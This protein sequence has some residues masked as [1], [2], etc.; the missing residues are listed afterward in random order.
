MAKV[1]LDNTIERNCIGSIIADESKKDRNDSISIIS[2]YISEVDKLMNFRN[3]KNIRFICNANSNSCNP[4]TL[5]ILINKYHAK[6]RTRNDIH[7]KMYIFKNSIFITSANATPNGIGLGT[8]EAAVK[9]SNTEII[10]DTRKWF[11]Q[12]WEDN[13]TRDVR[14][15]SSGKWAKLKANWKINNRRS[16]SK[17]SLYDL[18]ITKRIPDNVSFMFWHD[19][20]NAP[21]KERVAKVASDNNMVELPKNINNW[22][23]WMEGELDDSDDK[24]YEILEKILKKYYNQIMIN[25][26]VNDWPFNKA[27]FEDNFPSRLLDIPITLKWNKKLRLL[28]LYRLD[29]INPEFNFDNKVVKLINISIVENKYKWEKYFSSDE[30]R[31]GYCSNKRFYELVENCSINT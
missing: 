22:D 13:G 11:E 25:I 24:K 10:A 4:Y 17:P 26:K 30:G 19:V 1:I 16:N 2:P 29:N 27:F 14:E 8:I 6:V 15:F 23:Y 7:A 21:K 5:E 28:S 9:I 12:L 31:Y 18:I 20:K 3:T